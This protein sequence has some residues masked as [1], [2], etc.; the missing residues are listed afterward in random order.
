MHIALSAKQ[1]SMNKFFTVHEHT[2]HSQDLAPEDFFQFL[3]VKNALKRTHFQSVDEVKA[4]TTELLKM[5]T[6]NEP[7]RYFER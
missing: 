1:F 5:E 7:Q 2:P 4:K 3:K 6:L